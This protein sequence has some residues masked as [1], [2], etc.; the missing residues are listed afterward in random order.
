MVS[1]NFSSSRNCKIR[2]TRSRLSEFIFKTERRRFLFTNQKRQQLV[3]SVRICSHEK[4][5][6]KRQTQHDSVSLF[7]LFVL[8]F[9]KRKVTLFK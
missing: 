7:K 6:A 2:K 9:P 5:R 3:S 8:F 1:L 4:S